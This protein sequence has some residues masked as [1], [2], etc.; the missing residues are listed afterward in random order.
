MLRA[1]LVLLALLVAWLFSPPAW[2]YAVPLWLPFVLALGLELQFFVGGLL[3]TGEPAERGHGPQGADLQEFGWEGEPPEEDDPEFWSSPPAPK[4]RRRGL[5]RLL[6]PAL[7][8]GAVGLIVWGVS[9][10]R[11]WSALDSTAQ[12]RVEQTI[13]REARK[14]A[15]HPVTVT[16]DTSGHHVG[17]VQEADGLAEVG[18][19]H[20]WLTPGICYTLSQVIEGH[21]SH[22]GR[23]TGHAI[24]VLAHEAWHL[25]GV[26]NEG[27]ANCYAYQSG[28]RVGQ[29]LGLSHSVAYGLMEQALADNAV[30]AAS[31]E[32]VV[33]AGCV[34]GGKYD[35][36]PGSSQ[37]P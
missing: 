1:R 14:I 35:L 12:A 22:P 36:K 29:D 15:G 34:K 11:G 23:G 2:R 27:L 10:R 17:T 20:A 37:F 31:P 19:A 33:P 7:V 18:G 9:V 24:V 25:R 4:R 13:T 32:Y 26:A 28:V 16:C 3:A 8:L 21:A 5:G 30:D 6:G